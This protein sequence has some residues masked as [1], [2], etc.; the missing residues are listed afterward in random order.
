[1]RIERI[2]LCIVMLATCTATVADGQQNL[3]TSATLEWLRNP[4]SRDAENP[5]P[6]MSAT[7]REEKVVTLAAEPVPAFRYRFWPSRTSLKPGSAQMHFYR[8]IVSYQSILQWN[9]GQTQQLYAITGQELE[10]ISA[11][12]AMPWIDRMKTVFDELE[13]MANSEDFEWDFRF[14][15]KQGK[16]I[17]MTQLEEVQQARNLA[18]LLQLKFVV[19]VANQEHDAAVHTLQTGFRL[20]SFVGQGESLIQTLVGIAIEHTMYN[21]VEYAIR[22]PGF[23]NMYW[24]LRTLPPQLS[25]VESAVETELELAMRTLTVLSEDE[26]APL[27]DSEI[28]DRFRLGL[29]DLK[30]LAYGNERAVGAAEVMAA[31]LVASGPEAK[32]KLQAAGYPPDRLSKLTDLQASLIQ[33]GM[34]LR[35]QRDALLK[36]SK[37]GGLAGVQIGIKVAQQFESWAQ[38]NRGTVAGLVASM[39]FPAINNVVDANLRTRLSRN[40]LTTLEALRHYAATHDGNL[41]KDLESLV[42]TPAPIDPYT[43]RPFAVQATREGETQVVRMTSE[44]PHLQE[45]FRTLS[46]RF[47]IPRDK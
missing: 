13:M 26:I 21:A 18:R 9:H 29:G 22:T 32:R 23:P 45:A 4:K 27:S 47:S 5:G 12:E 20:A 42:D 30:S 37:V 3:G 35:K 2:V 8:A 36:A 7:P 28:L 17:W 11:N 6:V 24:A 25:N 31:I 38:A 16:D 15:D 44:V 43:E 40:R 19:H 1:M 34:E 41:P 10:E 14:R 46:V 39:L 33:S